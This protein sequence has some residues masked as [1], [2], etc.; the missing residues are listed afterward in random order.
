MIKRKGLFVQTEA[1]KQV[2]LNIQKLNV[3]IG[4]DSKVDGKSVL[5]AKYHGRSKWGK[6]KMFGNLDHKSYGL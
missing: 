2:W 5:K 4:P 1:M 3:L 6:N